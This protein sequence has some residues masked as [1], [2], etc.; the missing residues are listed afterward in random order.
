M[1]R[2]KMDE[3]TCHI[4]F[5][6]AMYEYLTLH[7]QMS[8]RFLNRQAESVS[9]NFLKFI[10]SGTRKIGS[11]DCAINVAKALQMQ[12]WE[13]INFVDAALNAFHVRNGNTWNTKTMVR[14]PEKKSQPKRL[15]SDLD[16]AWD[17]YE[18]AIAKH[19]T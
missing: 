1:K 7:E 11:R 10:T 12:D 2:P 14:L 19:K 15:K 4:K 8:A 13:L 5:A 16:K 17:E 3:F 18:A 9:P 6:K